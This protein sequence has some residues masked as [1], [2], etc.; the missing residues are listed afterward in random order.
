MKSV[1]QNTLAEFN[2]IEN[3]VGHVY[4]NGKE[5]LIDPYARWQGSNVHEIQPI[6]DDDPKGPPSILSTLM[7]GNFL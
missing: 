6:N 5:Y 7:E 2:T 1:E 3:S 4:M